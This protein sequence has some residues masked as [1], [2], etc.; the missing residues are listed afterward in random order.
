MNFNCPWRAQGITHNY[1]QSTSTVTKHSMAQTVWL[2]EEN[3]VKQAA[4]DTSAVIL[5]GSPKGSAVM[6]S[7]SHAGKV[8]LL[9]VDCRTSIISVCGSPAVPLAFPLHQTEDASDFIIDLSNAS[10]SCTILLQSL[11]SYTRK[12]THLFSPTLVIT[13]FK[14]PK[15][16]AAHV[17]HLEKSRKIL[18]KG[19]SHKRLCDSFLIEDGKLSEMTDLSAT[20]SDFSKLKHSLH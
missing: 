8:A 12:K 3:E 10:V 18:F 14:I 5:S 17:C 16:T 6:Q 13:C 20:V 15:S 1:Q 4:G 2:L 7:W 9:G 11:D 19:N